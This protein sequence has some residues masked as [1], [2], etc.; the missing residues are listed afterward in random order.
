M[1]QPLPMNLDLDLAERW[2][3]GWSLARGLPLPRREGGGL[4]VDVGCPEQLRRHVFIDAGPAL[5]ACAAEVHAPRIYLKAFVS[6]DDMRRALPGCW[7]IESPRYLMYRP[8]AP[9]CAVEPPPGY[10]ATVGAEHG[11]AVI[12][13]ADASG[14]TAATGRVVLNRGTAVFDRIETF[15]GHRRKGL[16]AA[17]MYGLEALA[18]QAGVRE[19][20]LVATE[21]G[22]QL[23]SRLGWL[24]AAPYSTAVLPAP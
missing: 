18:E 3:S 14:Q 12:R 16:G 21:A 17:L 10:F 7:N 20:L 22:R 19:R 1:P 23:Y 13:Y 24:V 2:L 11:A 8:T 9:G 4:V 6:P 15:E 5:R